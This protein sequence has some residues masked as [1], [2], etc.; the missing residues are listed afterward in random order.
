MPFDFDQIIDRRNTNSYKW[1]VKA[2]ELPMWVA[3]MDFQTATVIV[4]AIEEADKTRRF[5]LQYR[6]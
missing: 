4:R 6:P 2:D 5:W 3:D 1:D